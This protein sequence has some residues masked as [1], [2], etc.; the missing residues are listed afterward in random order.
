MTSFLKAVR[1]NIIAQ[2]I[3]SIA[4]GVLLAF[5]PDI[6][7]IT[8]VYLLALYLAVTGVVSLIA[9]FRTKGDRSGSFGALVSGVLLLALA[10]VVFVFPEAV[11]GFFSLILGLL[12][13]IGGGVNAVRAMEL[14]RYQGGMWVAALIA[15][16][17]IALG[18]VI[19]IV[20]PFDTTVMFVLVLG[21][22]LIVKGIAYLLISLWLSSAMKEMQ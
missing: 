13:V 20:N 11:A 8:I 3:L 2:A 6:T 14:R 10:L 12:L 1:S 5:W 9:Y 18:G 22:L 4:L 17:I 16:I 19:I 7:V 15:G 21:V